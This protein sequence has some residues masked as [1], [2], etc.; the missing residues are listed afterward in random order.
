MQLPESV[1]RRRLDSEFRELQQAGLEFQASPDRTEYVIELRASGWVFNGSMA[2]PQNVHRVRVRLNRSFPYPG[3]L[4]VAWLSPIFH[5]NIRPQDGKVCIHLLN[6][7]SSL[8]SVAGVAR[9]LVHLVEHPNTM[10]ALD[11]K[12]AEYFAKNFDGTRF[13]S[14][15][16]SGPRIV[17]GA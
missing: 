14:L 13:V 10:D 4:E 15:K 6:N 1:W 11:K 9:G 17:S 3:G 16:P 12:A 5:P 2:S 7:W 8:A